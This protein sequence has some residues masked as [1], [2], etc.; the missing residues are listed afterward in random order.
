MSNYTLSQILGNPIPPD[1]KNQSLLIVLC[2]LSVRVGAHDSVLGQGHPR[3]LSQ[4]RRSLVRTARTLDHSI[5]LKA[6]C[7]LG[8][9]VGQ[10]FNEHADAVFLFLLIT[11]AL[12]GARPAEVSDMSHMATDDR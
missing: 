8:T 11:V 4:G 5:G 10:D 9:A 6:K 3:K 2:Y 7:P 12:D 1:G